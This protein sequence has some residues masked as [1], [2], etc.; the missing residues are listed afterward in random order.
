MDDILI[1]SDTLA[2]HQKHVR[3]V[4]Q[5]LWE[6][7]L[8]AKPEKCS[9]HTHS[10]EYLGYI[11]SPDG[12][13]M[14]PSKVKAILD[15]PVPTTVK[16]VQAFLGF[17]NFYRRFIRHYSQV[18]RPLHELTRLSIPFEWTP[19]QQ[20]A[21]NFLKQAFTSAPILGHYDPDNL[22]I[23]ETDASEYVIGGILSQIDRTSGLL[24]PIAFYSRSLHA[25]EL[26]YDIYN[27]ELLSIFEAFKE[28]RPYLEGT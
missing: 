14:D 13:S 11:V 15:W 25:A 19:R 23:V 5:R 27:K 8:H 28:W 17:A 26:N 2:E 21:F 18:A 20:Q 10:I 4:L 24:H 16:Q 3:T 7:D 6:H 22:I 1:F 9:F 12:V